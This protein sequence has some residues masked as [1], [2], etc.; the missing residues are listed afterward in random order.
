MSR[1]SDLIEQV[2]TLNPELAKELNDEVSE[3]AKRRPFG[4][5]FERHTPESVRL[6]NR[7]VRL[8]DY[9]NVL[10]PRGEKETAD[11]HVLWHVVEIDDGGKTVRLMP[12]VEN[13]EE[14]SQG[15]FANMDDLVVVARFK[16]PIYP[17][18]KETGRVERGGDKPYQVVI[19]GENFH[20][21]ETLMYPY[22]GKVDC[23]YIDPPYNTGAKDWKYN[24]DYVDGNDQYAHSK[25][26]AMMERRLK[27][28]KRLLNPSKSVLI[29]TIDEKE[30]LRVGLLLEQMFTDARIQMISC[31]I[32]PQGVARSGGFSRSDEYIYY[33]MLG[34]ASPKAQALSDEWLGVGTTTKKTL[35]WCSL[36]RTGTNNMRSDRPN[37]FYPLYV[38]ADGKRFMG[39]GPSIDIDKDRNSVPAPDGCVAVWP[40]HTD[41]TEGCWQVNQDYVCEAHSRGYLRLGGFTKRGMAISYL[42]SGEQKKV[43]KG[44]F[45]VVGHRE[46]GSI[47]VS[48]EEYIQKFIPSTQWR[49]SAHDSSRNGTNMLTAILGDKR[50]TFPKSLY[51]VEDTLRFFV[52]EK[53]DALILDFFAGSGTTAHAVTRLNRQD[54]GHR[55]CICVTNNEVSDDEAKRFTKQGLRQGDPEWEAHGICEYVTKPRVRAA[56]TGLTPEGNP[57][58]GDYKFT[59]EFPMADGFE[60]NAVFFDLT[61]QDEMMVELD[62]AFE[63]IAPLL[64]MRAG[65]EGR[66]IK[67][68]KRDFDISERYAVLF[69]YAYASKFL[70]VI[71]DK[72]GLRVV[73]V[74]TDQDSR[75]Q[76]VV[77]ALPKGIEPVRLYESYLRSFRF[78]HGEV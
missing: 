42:K 62:Q 14:Q 46:D 59:D 76:D 13:K 75:F 41:F 60:E 11:S 9:V 20:A 24:N 71:Q 32:N 51:A 6:W 35:H 17:G 38:S 65:S 2:G 50:F 56:I 5:N 40:I 58:K 12:A 54:G 26:L 45:P 16:D 74:V 66:I 49:I 33:V 36:L 34:D 19:N 48:D 39:V 3:Y 29:L 8:G 27:L 7:P 52:S 61:Y 72:E 15:M 73:Y 37:L 68:R 43:E 47:I 21:L 67:D 31:R 69:N 53:P 44:L 30:Y 55:R 10:P 25:W 64:W 23:I 70:D 57:I 28:A 63:E 78:S 1:L 18:L 4:L 77:R 22:E